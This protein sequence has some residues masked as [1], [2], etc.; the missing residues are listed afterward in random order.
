[1]GLTEKYR[2]QDFSQIVGQQEIVKNIQ[3]LLKRYKNKNELLPPLLFLGPPGCG[4]TTLAQCVARSLYG[5]Q[6]VRHYKELNASDTR[7]IEVVRG[8]VKR[9][10]RIKGSRI[11]FLDEADNM[12]SDAQQ[13]MRRIME[14]THSTIFILSGNREH[15]IISPIKSRCVIFR[16]RRLDDR[17]VLKRVLEVCKGEG[18]QILPQHHD[19]LRM[20]VK[21]ARGDLRSAINDLEKLINEKEELST[22]NI[23]AMKEV[24]LVKTAL[25]YALNGDFD[26]SR[27]MVENAFIDA[28]YDPS[29]VLDALYGVVCDLDEK[30]NPISIRLFEKI[31]ETDYALKLGGSPIFQFVGF[32]AFAWLLPNLP[33]KCPALE[34]RK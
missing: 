31:Q 24:D 29:K 30:W 19:A 6:W 25:N 33:S 13:A 1:M 18:I 34:V 11:L 21:D 3:T 17:A 16:F 28:K 10:S 26:R 27:E 32:M 5:E 12:T 23:V 15:K 4:K 22:A 8:V 7:G 20:L 2:P 14:T 9:L